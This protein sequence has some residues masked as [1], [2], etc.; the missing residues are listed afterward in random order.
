MANL[1]LIRHG[2][3]EWNKMQRSQGCS[4]DIPLSEDGRMQAAAVAQRLKNEKIDMFFSSNLIRANETA[5]IIAKLHNKNV[6]I[7]NEFRELNMGCWEGLCFEDI[8]NK[9]SETLKIWRE[10]PH[11]AKIPMA[12]TI[13]ELRERSMG[14]LI[15]ILNAYPDK[16]I[17]I[18]SHGITIKTIITSIMGIE[19]SNLHKISQ[20]NT[21]LNIFEYI[22]GV[23]YTKLINDTCHLKSINKELYPF[24]Q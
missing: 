18:V 6:D 24:A 12:E 4:N 22:N 7:F 8:K 15:E 5:R 20:D 19:L 3:T 1:Y 13:L 17:L 9:Y 2:E 14:K 21:A 23:F 16:N 11:L 10:S